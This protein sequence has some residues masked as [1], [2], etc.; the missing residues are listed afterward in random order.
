MM[1]PEFQLDIAFL[2]T[3]TPHTTALN[4]KRMDRTSKSNCSGGR[5]SFAAASAND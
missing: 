1:R 5:Q 2:P 3:A 4:F